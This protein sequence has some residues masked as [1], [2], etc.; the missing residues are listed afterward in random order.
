MD[1]LREFT[2]N[3][4][5][6]NM[7]LIIHFSRSFKKQYHRINTLLIKHNLIYI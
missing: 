7:S 6:I 1:I 3:S 2:E 5:I 4:T